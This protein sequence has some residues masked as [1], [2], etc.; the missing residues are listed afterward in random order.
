MNEPHAEFLMSRRFELAMKMIDAARHED[1]V[2]ARK[3]R[4]YVHAAFAVAITTAFLSVISS[5]NIQ[6][7]GGVAPDPRFGVDA[8]E[9]SNSNNNSR[10]AGADLATLV[11]LLSV[12]PAAILAWHDWQCWHV[13][14]NLSHAL[15]GKKYAS[16]AEPDESNSSRLLVTLAMV[17]GIPMATYLAAI[18]WANSIGFTG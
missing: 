1:M 13:S 16:L 15:S 8:L 3:M 7:L 5:A 10:Y 11:L 4:P 14:Q 18:C 6:Y 2:L 17:F 9:I 12:I